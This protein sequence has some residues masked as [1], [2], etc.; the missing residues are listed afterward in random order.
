MRECF[1]CPVSYLCG[2]SRAHTK[3]CR[4]ASIDDDESSDDILFYGFVGLKHRAHILR[5][6][7]RRGDEMG[8]KTNVKA[9]MTKYRTHVQDNLYW[10]L[11][12]VTDSLIEQRGGWAVELVVE[13]ALVNS[14]AAREEALPHCH[15]DRENLCFSFV[16][17]VALEDGAAPTT[18]WLNNGSQFHVPAREGWLVIFY[19]QLLHSVPP[20]ATP[21]VTV[22]GN[23]YWPATV[24]KLDAREKER[25]GRR[26]PRAPWPFD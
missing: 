22:S 13:S 6:L 15:C 4:N 23:L 12:T 9:T 1:D 2:F 5:I 26:G 3:G 20:T 11:S 19:G 16:Y 14:Y 8:Y 24:E 17:Y 18:F 25:R 10:L 21:R 7:E